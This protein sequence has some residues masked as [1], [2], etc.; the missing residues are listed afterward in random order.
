VRRRALPL[1]MRAVLLLAFVAALGALWLYWSLARPIGKGEPQTIAIHPGQSA[2][3]VAGELQRKGLIRSRRAF[4]VAARWSG[5]G[6]RLKAGGYRFPPTMSALEI[7]DAL[8]NG[9]HQT[10][11]WLT[12][13]EGFTMRQI[14]ERVE[15]KGLGTAGALRRAAAA[16]T[17]APG[18]PLPKAGLEGYLFPDTYRVELGA[19]PG[20]LLAQMLRR[21]RD[22]VWQGVFSEKASYHGRSLNDIITLASCVEAEAKRDDERPVIAGV[23]ANRLERG[24]KLEC[25]ATVQYAL[26]AERKAR[27]FNKDLLVD[28]EYNTYLHPGLPPGPIC[29]PGV[30]SIR[31]AMNPAR[32]PYL[33]Y[34]AQPDGSHVFSCTY[35]EHQAAIARIRREHQAGSRTS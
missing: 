10:W 17:F 33:Y 23:L 14:A 3:A 35:A 1:A 29:S 28:S 25:D 11:R 12:I 26:G 21:F 27:L 2:R 19:E 8:V 24:M 5:K 22:A 31:A 32:V 9:T 6:N 15:E 30:A 34:V 4:L 16:D 7:L 18:F 13:P 20:S